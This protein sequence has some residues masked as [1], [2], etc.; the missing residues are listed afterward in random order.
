MEPLCPMADGHARA[1]LARP[2]PD[3]RDRTGVPG[4]VSLLSGSGGRAILHGL[5][6]RWSAIPCGPT[7]WVVRNRSVGRVGGTAVSTRTCRG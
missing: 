6:A 4:P 3:G 5:P 7:G 2:S 1:T